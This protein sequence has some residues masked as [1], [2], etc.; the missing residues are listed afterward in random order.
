M[1]G[2][3]FKLRCGGGGDTLEALTRCRPV[4]CLQVAASQPMSPAAWQQ[5]LQ[6]PPLFSHVC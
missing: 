4:H 2:R 3:R 5:P 1:N 6:A